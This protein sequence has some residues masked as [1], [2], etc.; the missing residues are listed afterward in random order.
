MVLAEHMKE[1]TVTTVTCPLLPY[2]CGFW[3]LLGPSHWQKL[4]SNSAKIYI[5][6]I[7]HNLMAIQN[8]LKQSF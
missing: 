5:S 7:Q 4:Y 3:A 1:N 8:K 6:V 2:Y